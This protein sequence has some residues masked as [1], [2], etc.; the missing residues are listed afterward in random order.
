MI[1]TPAKRVLGAYFRPLTF[2]ECM[3]RLILTQRSVDSIPG[4]VC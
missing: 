4:F 3:V 2:V 1:A